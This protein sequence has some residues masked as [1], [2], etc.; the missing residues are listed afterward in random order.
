MQSKMEF[1]SEEDYTMRMR[2][3]IFKASGF[4]FM[5]GKPNPAI[6]AALGIMAITLMAACS[7]R[8]DPD[9]IGSAIVEAQTYQVM[10][11]VQGKLMALSKQEG[12]GVAAEELLA[13][14][15]SIPFVLQL[16]EVQGGLNEL[17]SGMRAKNNEIKAAM[18]EIRGLEK[19]YARIAPLVKEGSLPPQQE[20]KL[21]SGLETARLKLSAARDMQ[22]SLKGKEQGLQARMAQIKE[23][24]QRCYLRSTSAGRILTRYKNPGETTAP[25]QPIYEIG[26]EDTLQADFFVPQTWLANLKYGQSVRLRLDMDDAKQSAVFLPATISWIGQEAEFSPK[27]IQTRESR[28]ELV[29]R[30]RALAANK[31]GMLKRGLPVEVWK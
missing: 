10:S 31:D 19:D 12:Q 16:Q 30:V 3:R 21:S 5:V 15:D 13:V 25:G 9:F 17:A 27:N 7:G 28:N 11:M 6:L 1:R 14:V 8:T 18:S 20:D 22:A 2:A 24:I 23:Q 4:S 29:F 26:K